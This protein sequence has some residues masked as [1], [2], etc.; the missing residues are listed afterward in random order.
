MWC[1]YINL[2][3]Q[4]HVPTYLHLLIQC[5]FLLA[6]WI[7]FFNNIFVTFLLVSDE[8]S[9][10]SVIRKKILKLFLRNDLSCVRRG[11]RAKI[12]IILILSVSLACRAVAHIKWESNS[13]T[14]LATICVLGSQR[15]RP[16]TNC[17]GWRQLRLRVNNSNFASDFF[18][19]ISLFIK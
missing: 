5:F 10:V 7:I 4:C 14:N 3:F 1:V 6:I 13:R 19:T 15:M 16:L 17:I 9:A 11:N 18:Q 2:K 12:S 8:F